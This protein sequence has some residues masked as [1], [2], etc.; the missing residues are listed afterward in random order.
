MH[1]PAP[2]LLQTSPAACPSPFLRRLCRVA[3]FSLIEVTLAIAIIAFAFIA[4]IGLLPAG[5]GIFN[6]TVDSTNEMRISNHLSSL[7]MASDFENL[8]SGGSYSSNLYYYDIDGGF[9]DSEQQPN[10][11]YKDQRIYVA[12]AMFDGQNIPKSGTANADYDQSNVAIKAVILVGRNHEAVSS[13]IA[14]MSNSESVHKSPPHPHK[15]RTI[16][17]IISKTDGKKAP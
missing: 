10:L 11:A 6:Q 13:Y 7:L 15:V 17:V 16:P 4:L 3:G 12:R 1:T 8:K 5:L 14:S 2:P 9:L